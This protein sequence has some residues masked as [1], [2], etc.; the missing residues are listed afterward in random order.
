MP[1]AAE[2]DSAARVPWRTELARRARYHLGLKTAGIS[3]FMWLFFMAYFQVLRHPTSAVTL[4]PLTAL[5][6]AIPF[7]PAALAVYVSLWLYVG[8]APGLMPTLRSAA[9]YGLWAAGLCGTGLALFH[10]FPTAVP[11]PSPPIDAARH[12]GFAMLQG[13]D[14][15]GNACPSLHVASA[16]FTGAWIVRL[17]KDA[18]APAPLQWLNALWMVAIVWSTLAT[19]Q[20]VAIDAAAGAALGAAFAWASLRGH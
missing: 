14:A 15:A 2:P 17:L 7:T 3:L 18:G 6:R 10:F 8:I 5:D 1:I 13:V 16:V 9:V 4:M 11:P 12:F 19:R 20:H